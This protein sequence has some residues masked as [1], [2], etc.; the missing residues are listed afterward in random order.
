MSWVSAILDH[1]AVYRLWQA[2]FANKKLEPVFCHNDITKVRKVLDVGCG[3]GTNT[4]H[5]KDADYLGIDL[6]KQYIENARQR[7]KREFVVADVITY[8]TE[9]RECFDF[10]LVN[11]ILHH[12]DEPT[13]VHILSHL[14]RLLSDEG[15]IHILELVQPARRGI[16]DL[17]KQWDR[18]VYARPVSDWQQICSAIFE[19]VVFEPY[20]VKA[21]GVTLWNMVYFKGRAM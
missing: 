4:R 7:Y 14:K 20:E 16:A 2:P 1:P 17:L 19:T 8:C 12:I 13:V 6:N 15:D 18:G 11:S 3:P 21:L 10:I 9:C 5:F